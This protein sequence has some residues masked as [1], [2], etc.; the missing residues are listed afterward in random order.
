MFRKGYDVLVDLVDSLRL[1]VALLLLVL[2]AI[3]R[4]E[5]IEWEDLS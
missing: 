4:R 5:E 3:I 1:W 2:L